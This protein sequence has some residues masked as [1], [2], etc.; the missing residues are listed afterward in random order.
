[1]PLTVQSAERRRC[2]RPSERARAV[3]CALQGVEEGVMWLID[4]LRNHPRALAMTDPGS[5]WREMTPV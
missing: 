2:V 3:A 1:M 5:S 4:V